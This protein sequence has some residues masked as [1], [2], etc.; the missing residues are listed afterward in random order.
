MMTPVEQERWAILALAGTMASQAYCD[1]EMERHEAISEL[2]I[3]IENCE[4]R[5]RAKA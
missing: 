4:Q 3:A 1:G 2:I 5:N